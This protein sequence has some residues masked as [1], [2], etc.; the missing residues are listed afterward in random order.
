MPNPALLILTLFCTQF[1][2]EMPTLSDTARMVLFVEIFERIMS[3]SVQFPRTKLQP[4]LPHQALMQPNR[5]K[6]G[7][8]R[9]TLCYGVRWEMASHSANYTKRDRVRSLSLSLQSPLSLH[10]HS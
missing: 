10:T 3:E 7:C 9:F 6:K 8:E 4:L 1:C 2:V 5:F